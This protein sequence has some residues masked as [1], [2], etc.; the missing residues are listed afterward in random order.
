MISFILLLGL[1]YSIIFFFFAFYK[2]T[3]KIQGSSV[4]LKVNITNCKV[5]IFDM[6][7][8]TIP[9]I[10]N[11]TQMPFLRGSLHKKS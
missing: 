6:G 3:I 7:D 11:Q 1:S 4:E 9:Q 10:I 5:N 8:S 2:K